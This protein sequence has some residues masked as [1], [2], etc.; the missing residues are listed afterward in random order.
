MKKII[1]IIA[2]LFVAQYI[3]AQETCAT[4]IP[5]TGGN[6]YVVSGVNGMDVPSPICT[7]NGAVTN[8]SP[9]GEWYSYTPTGDHTVTITTD[10][11]QNNPRVDTRFHVYTGTC[12]QLTCFAGDDDSGAAFSSVGIFNVTANTTYII[13]FDNRWSSVGFT[14]QIL[15]NAVVPQLPAP[16]TFSAQT[17]STINNN[18]YNICGVD[19]NGDFLDD[20][21]GVNTTNIKIHYQNPDG[22]F[23]MS[24]KT[25]TAANFLPSWSIAA[26]DFN[27]DG[28]NDL[29]YGSAYG[30]T[31]AKSNATG[32]AYTLNA[33][34]EYIFCQRTNFI[35]INN[36]GELDAFSCHDVN[37][38]VYYINNGEGGFTYYQSGVTPGAYSLGV[39]PG[40][41]NYASLWTDYDN[42]G[43][44]DM[45]ISKCSGPPCE[46]HRNNGD[47]TFT[48]VS[49][50]AG[51]NVTPIQSWSS[52]IAD[53]DNDGD[54]DILIGSNGGSGNKF[55]KNNLNTTNS[56]EEAFTNITSGSGWDMNNSTSRDYIA[57]DFDNDGFVD[58]MGGGNKI[59]YNN[60]GNMTFS[61]VSVPMGIGAVG[62][63]NNDGFLD[64]QSNNTI[65]RNSGNA[66]NWFKVNLLGLQSNT[67]GIGA[68][69]EI[70]GDWGVQIRDVRSGEGFE[71]MSTLNV[72]FGLGEATNINKV[73]IKW[74]S[75]LVDTIL[76]P[77]INQSLKVTEG[78][79]LAVGNFTNAA[80]SVYPNPAKHVLNIQWNPTA[81]T[82]KA[83]EV[84]DL[85]GK[86]ILKTPVNNQ[87]IPVDALS[88][89]TYILLLKD[90]NDKPYIQKFIKE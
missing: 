11:P 50:L 61:P 77:T 83:A 71:F 22:T 40:G 66:N 17:I 56:T 76:N 81:Y 37:P 5:I 26:G 10:I 31:F 74:P 25:T 70:Y 51:I 23:T 12:G 41:G 1:L 3:T 59:M 55:F 79:T 27:R 18:D 4:A 33:P 72:H 89:G 19:M 90:Q 28:F 65:Y 21:V 29:I 73:V 6:L 60:G 64:I 15:E 69:I 43:D 36:D 53:Y 34:G 47:G 84:F 39:T 46:L 45:F 49:A 62:D 63:F 44:V 85:N 32:T 67:N 54:M 2:L 88:T 82:F 80:F 24:N 87:S 13:A 9:H 16:V 38:N 48:D 75:G 14:F 68:R 42:D 8:G 58:V 78:T 86:C 57:Y 20:L 35:D 7:P 30:L 52:A